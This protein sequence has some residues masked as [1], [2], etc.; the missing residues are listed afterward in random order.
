MNC[1][2]SEIEYRPYELAIDNGMTKPEMTKN[3]STPS[4]P[5]EPLNRTQSAG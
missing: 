1:G 3:T 5:N 2:K 4:Q